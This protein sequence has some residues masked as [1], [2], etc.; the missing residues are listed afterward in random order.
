MHRWWNTSY[1]Y[2]IP[3]TVQINN[4]TR[5]NKIVEVEFNLTQAF[6]KRGYQVPARPYDFKVIEVDEKGGLIQ[7]A[8]SCQCHIRHHNSYAD[9]VLIALT[10]Y[11]SGKCQIGTTR[12]FYAYFRTI[13]QTH[14]CSS[15][16]SYIELTKAVMHEGQESYKI[17]T[18]SATYIYHKNGGDLPALLIQMVLTGSV[19]IPG[20]DQMV[21]IVAYRISFTQKVISILVT[22]DVAA[23]S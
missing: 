20:G 10:F 4:Y 11:M 15:Q 19:S 14:T 5:I 6:E 3:L 12:R 22:R 23:K 16:K 7:D 1:A 17:S 2:R 13:E 8:I 9:D 18:P 21:F